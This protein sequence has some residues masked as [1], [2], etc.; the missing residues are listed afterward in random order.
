VKSPRLASMRLL[1]FTPGAVFFAM[2]METAAREQELS[3]AMDRTAETAMDFMVATAGGGVVG[4]SR[5][6]GGS[7]DARSKQ[8]KEAALRGAGGRE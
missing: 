5:G 7:R 1:I 8:E 6:E 3:A 2:S 4:G